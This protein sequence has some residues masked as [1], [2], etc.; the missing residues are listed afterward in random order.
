MVT[1]PL[2]FFLDTGMSQQEILS[3]ILTTNQLSG[4]FVEQRRSGIG[5]YNTLVQVPVA[6]P[7]SPLTTV[8]VQVREILRFRYSS[9]RSLA[10]KNLQNLP[11]LSSDTF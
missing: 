7:G 5:Q 11:A 4:F 2:I 6:V 1:E 10:G 3:V 8:E 9:Q